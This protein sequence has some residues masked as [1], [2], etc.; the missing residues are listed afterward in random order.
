MKKLHTILAIATILIIAGLAVLT[1]TRGTAPVE[2]T[3]PAQEPAAQG[4]PTQSGTGTTKPVAPTGV[5]PT[6]TMGR[7]IFTITDDAIALETI[8][9]IVITV[10][11]LSVHSPKKGWVTISK[12]PQY[13]D[14][15]A[16][17]EKGTNALFADLIMTP[18]TYDQVRFAVGKIVIANKEGLKNVEAKLP[19]NTL[20]FNTKLLVEKGK[21]SAVTLDIISSKSLHQTGSGTIMFLPVIGIHAQHGIANVQALG[22]DVEFIGGLTDFDQSWGMDETG[23]LARGYVFDPLAKIELIGRSTIRVIPRDEKAADIKVS[24]EQAIDAAIKAGYIETASSIKTMTRYLK[25]VWQIRGVKADTKITVYVDIS[26]GAVV[27]AE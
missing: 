20:T 18:D 21:T 25:R 2:T 16:L 9:S 1:G 26:T 15:L 19:S 4:T 11:E 23:T 12:T 14:L 7:V 3:P 24:A 8:E 17:H 22:G 6:A 13:F 5:A 27:A 10:N